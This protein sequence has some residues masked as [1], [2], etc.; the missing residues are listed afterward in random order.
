MSHD[1]KRVESVNEEPHSQ[2]DPKYHWGV[3]NNVSVVFVIFPCF[4]RSRNSMTYAKAYC[5]DYW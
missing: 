5:Q 3:R 4:L 2:D 1:G